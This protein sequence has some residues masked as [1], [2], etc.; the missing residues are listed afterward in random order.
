[1]VWCCPNALGLFVVVVQFH[2]IRYFVIEVLFI[3]FICLPHV[4][5]LCHVKQISFLLI[6]GGTFKHLSLCCTQEYSFISHVD[7]LSTLPSFV[8]SG[9]IIVVIRLVVFSFPFVDILRISRFG[10]FFLSFMKFLATFFWASCHLD[11]ACAPIDLR[12]VLS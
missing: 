3:Q 7:I 4:S 12:V 9:S 2:Q 6:G 5:F 1:M 8:D 11:C 10:F